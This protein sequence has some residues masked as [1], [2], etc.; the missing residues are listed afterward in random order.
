MQLKPPNATTRRQLAAA[1]LAILGT[2]A[3]HASADNYNDD[4]QPWKAD[5]GA[6]YYVEGDGRI[7][8]AEAIVN[9]KRVYADESTTSIKMT[10]D[11]LTG[12]SPNGA[13]PSHK[14]QTFTTPSG[15]S[16]PAGYTPPITYTTPSGNVVTNG[17]K[18]YGYTVQP[19]QLP[20]DPSFIDT[21]VA[22]SFFSR[23][24]A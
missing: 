16:A 15:S 10:L 12:G 20:V 9:L 7:K 14:A 1:V 8:V 13:A 3:G 23:T 19:G 17:G 2:S 6:L 24:G 11:S 22:A 4:D 21:R 18:S 5:T